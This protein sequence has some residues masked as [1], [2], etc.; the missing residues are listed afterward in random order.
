MEGAGSGGL[1]AGRLQGGVGVGSP[2]PTHTHISHHGE[3]DD[4]ADGATE[5]HGD[6]PLESEVVGGWEE[7]QQASDEAFDTYKL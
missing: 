2:R 6:L 5:G 4:K 3:V 1:V 7:V